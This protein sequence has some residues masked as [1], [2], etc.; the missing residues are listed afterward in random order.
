MLKLLSDHSLIE[1]APNLRAH[2]VHLSSI[3]SRYGFDDIR[4]RAIRKVFPLNPPLD[5]IH[6]AEL[7]VHGVVM[8]GSGGLAVASKVGGR[9]QAHNGQPKP[10]YFPSPS[11]FYKR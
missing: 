11:S 5:P 9:R 3:S 10:L 8:D 7:A 1:K 6:L 4:E 2:W